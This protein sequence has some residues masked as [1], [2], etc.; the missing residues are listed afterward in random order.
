[1]HTL[2]HLH[3][4]ERNEANEGGVRG[5]ETEWGMW[6]YIYVKSDDRGSAMRAKD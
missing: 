6:M 5:W 3:K 1:M 2:S 4:T